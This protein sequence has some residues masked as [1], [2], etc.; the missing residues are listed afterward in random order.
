MRFWRHIKVI[1]V[2]A[3][4]WLFVVPGIALVLGGFALMGSQLFA[5]AREPLII[6]SIRMDFHWAIVG[7]FLVLIGYQLLA[8]YLSTNL[9]LISEGRGGDSLVHQM[10][11]VFTLERVIGW[12]W[13]L[14]LGGVVLD[15]VITIRWIATGFGPLVKRDT[16]VFVLGST[17]IVLGIQQMLNAFFYSLLRDRATLNA[18]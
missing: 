2:L 6:G 18:V 10:L 13:L 5:G 15:L 14:L 1:L 4:T 9:F 7:G 12:A 11:K 17:L 16:R 8:F 3:P